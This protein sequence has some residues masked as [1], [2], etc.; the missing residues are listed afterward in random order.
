M[1][2]SPVA[3]TLKLTIPYSQ[4]IT[5]A[6]DVVI[7]GRSLTVTVAEPIRLADG[8]SISQPLASVT[9]S[10]LYVVVAAGVTEIGSSLSYPDTVP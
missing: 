1:R 10:S 3:A 2:S 5:S 8:S 4:V 6:G 9:L 7:S